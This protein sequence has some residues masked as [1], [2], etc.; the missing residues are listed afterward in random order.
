MRHK[1]NDGRRLESARSRL[2]RVHRRLTGASGDV[3]PA[4]PRNALLHL[5]AGLGSKVGDELANPRLVL[6]WL[7]QAMAS[8]LW[9][10]GWLVPIRDAGA[11]LPQLALAGRI[12]SMARRRRAWV[13][14]GLVQGCAALAMAAL[15]LWVPCALDGALG[16][17][18]LLAALA[19]GSVAR[20]ASSIASKDVLGRTVAKSRRGAITGW[21]GA[22]AS[23][24]ALVAA[25]A[26]ASLGGQASPDPAAPVLAVALALAGVGWIASAFAA[27]RIEEPEVEEDARTRDA[28]L[29]A[30][31]G[32]GRRLLRD[33][34]GFRR[35]LAARLLALSSAMA[36][37]F[38]ALGAA[39]HDAPAALDRLGALVFV[40]AVVGMVGKPVW[41]RWADRSSPAVMACGCALASAS[42]AAAAFWAQ[43]AHGAVAVA[44][45]G[46]LAM[47]HAG[48]RV[49]RKTYVLDLA[50]DDNRAVMVAVGNTLVGLALLVTGAAVGWAVHVWGR[51]PV[52]W[53]L[54]AAAASAAAIAAS[55]RR[56]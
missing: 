1:G 26:L 12:R 36:M 32:E 44:L 51:P 6:A 25:G 18:L 31:L 22:I 56:P 5:L 16:G 3:P 11:L 15:A 33:V 37:P 40:S 42:C 14:G 35:F 45:Y 38:V 20:A 8:P 24:V 7:L 43:S 48:I 46:L 27:A 49:G 10:V 50:D 34:A 4:E 41:G 54:A 17:A 2:E 39:E 19:V 13:E 9:M 21:A 55:L 52:L 53:A 47:A 29:V 30:T 28:G 23:A